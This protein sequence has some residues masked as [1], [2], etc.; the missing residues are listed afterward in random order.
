MAF[1]TIFYRKGPYVNNIC[2]II[3]HFNH[4]TQTGFISS[5]RVIMNIGVR[6]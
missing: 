1:L 2:F 6:V 5:V 3:K 4:S